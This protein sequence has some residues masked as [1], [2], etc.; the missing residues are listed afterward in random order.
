MTRQSFFVCRFWIK[1]AP[2]ALN[3]GENVAERIRTSGLP[4]RRRPLYPAEL[5]RLINLIIIPYLRGKCKTFFEIFLRGQG[6][7]GVK[8]PLS[9]EDGQISSLTFPN[10]RSYSAS[11]S[12]GVIFFISKSSCV[13]LSSKSIS[14]I[15]FINE[16]S[17]S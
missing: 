7:W 16:T 17:H 6:A 13:S 10:I 5:Q 4:L 9:G 1:K 8:K 14:L 2:E 11:I 15:F 12:S 3:F